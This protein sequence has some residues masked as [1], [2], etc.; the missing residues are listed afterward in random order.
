MTYRISFRQTVDEESDALV[1]MK[2]A[3]RA[4]VR[5]RE[6]E[7][8]ANVLAS[9]GSWDSICAFGGLVRVAIRKFVIHLP[10][11]SIINWTGVNG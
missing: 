5:P 6:Q 9:R 1:L 4:N 3:T 2:H 10:L 8:Q 11:M 7:V